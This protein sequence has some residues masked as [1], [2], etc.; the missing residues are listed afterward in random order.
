VVTEPFVEDPRDGQPGRWGECRMLAYETHPLRRNT[1]LVEADV[2]TMSDLRNA[3][4]IVSVE[5]APDGIYVDSRS[6][7]SVIVSLNQT[8]VDRYRAERSA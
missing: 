2:A 3:P 5:P 1:G 4:G 7:T 8:V 6:G